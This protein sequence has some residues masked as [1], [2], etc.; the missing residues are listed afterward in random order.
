MYTRDENARDKDEDENESK[1]M[2]VNATIKPM[3]GLTLKLNYLTGRD[4]GNNDVTQ[5]LNAD[6]RD[7]TRL[8]VT[9]MYTMNSM[10]D[11]ALHYSSLATEK[12]DSTTTLFD[13][14]VTSIALYAGAK[15]ETW[16]AGLRYEMVQDDDDQNFFPGSAADGTFDNSYSAITVTGWYNV[17]TN[18]VLKAEIAQHSADKVGSF[19]DDTDVDDDSMMTY[20]LG[21]MYR[22]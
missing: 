2:G 17:D 15:M 12:A 10:Y 7:T 11:F 5:G 13:E 1:H 8:N 22:F 3:E 16:G 9:A 6:Y 4:G 18:A 20:G 14:E 21:F 19:A